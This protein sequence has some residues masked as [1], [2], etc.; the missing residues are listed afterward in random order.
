MGS[1]GVIGAIMSPMT[2][3]QQAPLV[4]EVTRGA[5]VESA[6][7]VDAVVVDRDGVVT[8]S[9]GDASRPILPRSAVKPIQALPLLESGAADRF[10]LTDVQL[11]LACA[12]HDGE[13]KHIAEIVG[14]LDRI[15]L[16]ETALECGASP[17]G[18]EPSVRAMIRSG[19]EPGPRHNN[20]SGKHVGL[21]TT[22][23]H[24]GYPIAG[25]TRPDHPIQ[26]DHVTPALA[27]LCGIDADRLVP[28][29]DG[30]GIPVWAT[31]L[32]GMAQGWA[33]LQHRPA[34][35]R[36]LSAMRGEAWLVAGS[37]RLC[38]RIIEAASG[39]TVVKTGAEGVF[40][41]VVPS[42]GLGIAI[43]ARDGGRRAAD[44]VIGWILG[45]LGVLEPVDTRP[46]SNWSGTPVGEI[47]VRPG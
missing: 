24:L 27:K 12:S 1:V 46:H 4:V 17:P 16:E 38:T 26:R 29:I 7:V 41:A 35:A 34:G 23:V 42:R 36:L 31:P 20:C 2:G 15:G 3:S 30:C 43:K 19:V 6:H 39:D 21:L 10:G 45:R 11:A 5:D 44:A 47:R 32:S 33:R 9:W 28:G 18:H 8:E 25:Y 37:E 14:W 40:G 13:P 22:C